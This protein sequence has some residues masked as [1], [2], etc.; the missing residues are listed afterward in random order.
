M[1]SGA[2]AK[3]RIDPIAC[4]TQ[5]RF[6]QL[7]D[8]NQFR[9]T[10]LHEPSIVWR[11]RNGWVRRRIQNGRDRFGRILPAHRCIKRHRFNCRKQ[12]SSKYRGLTITRSKA[13]AV[14]ANRTKK[15]D[16]R[17]P[18][19]FNL[20]GCIYHAVIRLPYTPIRKNGARPSDIQTLDRS[21]SFLAQ[22]SSF[23]RYRP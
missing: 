2:T 17:K 6:C 14:R 21:P 11:N 12:D 23:T 16:R 8:G 7:C 3:F 1:I 19:G 10:K 15:P 5:F 13:I 22:K 9:S 18:S 20:S 4:Y